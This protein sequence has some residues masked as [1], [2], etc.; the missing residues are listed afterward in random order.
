M[1]RRWQAVAGSAIRS[2]AAFATAIASGLPPKVEPCV[3]SVMPWRRPVWL[4]Q[5]ATG[6]PHAQ[7]LRD[8]HHVGLPRRQPIGARTACRCG[9]CR[10]ELRR[11]SA[12]RHA[13]RIARR[14]RISSA[15]E[16]A[17]TP[18]SPCTGSTMTAAVVGLPTAASTRGMI[19]DVELT[20]SRHRRSKAIQVGGIARRI[21]RGIGPAVERPREADDVHPFCGAA[22]RMKTTCGLDRAFDRFGAGVAEE[23]DRRRS[24]PPPACRPGLLSG[25]AA[26]RSTRAK[27]ARPVRSAPRPAPDGMAERIGGD[28]ADTIEPAHPVGVDQP[29]TFARA[30]PRPAPARRRASRNW[31]WHTPA[32][33]RT[34]YI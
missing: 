18:P 15:P 4:T 12:A 19:V 17:R 33:V 16:K 34:K 5:A 26:G 30:R 29:W 24:K 10:T 9:P 7:R 32:C 27:A 1:S 20:K 6:N 21:Y 13:R 11:G 2:N 8:R 22:G 28:P 23:H 3:A 31:T 25:N 14:S